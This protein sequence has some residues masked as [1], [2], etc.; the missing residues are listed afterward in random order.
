M[1]ITAFQKASEILLFVEDNKFMFCLETFYQNI[2][3]TEV[4]HNQMLS[5]EIDECKEYE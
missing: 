2:P 1:Q 3:Y 5:R 4:L